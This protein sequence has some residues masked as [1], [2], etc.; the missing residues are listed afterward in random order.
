[1]SVAKAYTYL[2]GCKINCMWHAAH[3]RTHSRE[4]TP[5]GNPS[6]AV[7]L[8]YNCRTRTRTVPLEFYLPNSTDGGRLSCTRLMPVDCMAVPVRRYSV[9][10][11]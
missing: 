2:D 3:V 8:P 11:Y 10:P 7:Q 9:Q 1:M 4:V 5:L 6:M